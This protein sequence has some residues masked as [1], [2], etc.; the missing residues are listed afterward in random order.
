MNTAVLNDDLF[1]DARVEEII[2]ENT[3]RLAIRNN[4]EK[5]VKVCYID[6]IKEINI[7]NDTDRLKALFMMDLISSIIP[8][9]AYVKIKIL[10]NNIVTVFNRNLDQNINTLLRI[11][12]NSNASYNL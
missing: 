11:V 6:T 3:L 4:D 12:Q 5:N 1:H 8:V 2:N 9:G 10:E 7:I